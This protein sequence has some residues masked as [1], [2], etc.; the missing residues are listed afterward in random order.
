M[1]DSDFER[2]YEDQAQALF[3]FLAYRTGDRALAED[4]LGDA[5]ERALRSRRR[6]DPA[7]ASA[8]TWLYAIAL[9]CLRD[10]RRRAEAEGGA[11]DRAGAGSEPAA[12]D[13]G[14]GR[15]EDRD[16]LARAMATLSEEERETVALRY[17]GEMT[18]PE[19]A[20][21]L[22]EKLTTVEGALYRKLCAEPSSARAKGPGRSATASRDRAGG[23][24]PPHRC[25]VAGRPTSR[26]EAGSRYSARPGQAGRRGSQDALGDRPP[27]KSAE[28]ARYSPSRRRRAPGQSR[29]SPPGAPPGHRST[30]MPPSP[31]ASGAPPTVVPMLGTPAAPASR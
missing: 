18:A 13:R 11:L 12:P 27:G 30:T 22:G 4:L 19:M 29:A 17:G 2:L 3:G 16:E 28:W 15:V 6:Y 5:F 14:L 9:N 21:L 31:I 10:Q 8:K 20:E 23:E 25:A 1:R 26:N 7:K 24:A